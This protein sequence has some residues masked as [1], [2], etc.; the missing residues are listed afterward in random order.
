[1]G[2]VVNYLYAN[3]TDSSSNFGNHIIDF[4]T[5]HILESRIPPP[6]LHF[7]SFADPPPPG[8]YDFV[9]LPGCTMITAGQNPGLNRIEQLGC[10]IYGLALSFWVS[11]PR[12]GF[13][14]RKRI[15]L[16]E[17]ATPPDLSI[18]RKLRQPIGA[19]DSYTYRVLR[20]HGMETYYVGC[21]TLFLPADGVCD[22][23]YV[24]MSLG[25][26]RVRTQTYAAHRLS[27]RHTIVGIVHEPADYDRFRA[28]GWKLPL[29]TYEGDTELYISYFKR[30]SVVISGRLHGALPALAFGKRVF[31]F[32]TRDSRTTI[33]EDLGVRIHGYHELGGAIEN[34]S[35]GFNRYLLEYFRTNM[36]KWLDQTVGTHA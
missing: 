34:A 32:G 22:D 30:A 27:R 4:A 8:L 28:A 26:G 18:A 33:L 17:R 35:S 21:P 19:R 14:V 12:P 20:T 5:R 15:V 1:M 25:R 36:D 29:V 10:P 7:D 3:F 13:L 6:A 24:L 2:R 23:G 31:Y 9:L 16:A 11:L